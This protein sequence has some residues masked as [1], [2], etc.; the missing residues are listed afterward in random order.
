[1]VRTLPL[2]ATHS[3]QALCLPRSPPPD[4]HPPPVRLVE[5][6]GGMPKA[7]G[8]AQQRRVAILDV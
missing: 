8:V 3:S 7:L 5:G 1:M 4:T 6:A 2:N